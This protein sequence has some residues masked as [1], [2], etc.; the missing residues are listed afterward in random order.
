LFFDHPASGKLDMIPSLILLTALCFSAVGFMPVAWGDTAESPAGDLPDRAESQ[1]APE[2]QARPSDFDEKA[3]RDR[4]NQ[5][6]EARRLSDEATLYFM[7]SGAQ[8]GSLSPL[9][10]HMQFPTRIL[11]DYAILAV[12]LEDGKVLVEVEMTYLLPNMRKPYKTSIKMNWVWLNGQL[13]LNSHQAKDAESKK[14]S[15]EPMAA[16]AEDSATDAV[17]SGQGGKGAA[18]AD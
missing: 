10:F 7:E 11:E 16:P 18:Q 6:L 9:E 8:D 17:A 1:A 2:P 12:S 14:P 13:Y 15:E 5:Y 4:V 3:V